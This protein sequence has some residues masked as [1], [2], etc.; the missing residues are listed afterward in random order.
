MESTGSLFARDVEAWILAQVQSRPPLDVSQLDA[1]LASRLAVLDVASLRALVTKATDTFLKAPRT[2]R[3]R[4]VVAA[5]IN[6]VDDI[7]KCPCVG[8]ETILQRAMQGN[9]KPDVGLVKLLIKAGHSLSDAPPGGMSPRMALELM[10]GKPSY[11]KLSVLL[12]P[13]P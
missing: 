10:F 11:Y 7:N 9:G 4:A 6:A 5:L 8:L 12:K 3:N 13:D 2:S 1:E